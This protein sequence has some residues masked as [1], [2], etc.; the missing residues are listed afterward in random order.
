MSQSFKNLFYIR[1][2]YGTVLSFRSMGKSL[3]SKK[4]ENTVLYRR[5]PLCRG[6]GLGTGIGWD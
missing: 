1:R 4:P 6:H 2:K 3:K 5:T